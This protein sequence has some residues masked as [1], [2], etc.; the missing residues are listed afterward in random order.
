MQLIIYNLL[1]EPFRNEL[2]IPQ[3]AEIKC[4]YFNLPS[5][6]S[7]T[8]IEFFKELD[9]NVLLSGAAVLHYLM[10]KI[11]V[12]KHFWPPSLTYKYGIVKNYFPDITADDIDSEVKNG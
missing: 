9:R 12:E 8:Q 7:K 2:N 1:A 6:V 3:D 11:F 5:D 4:G 10:Q